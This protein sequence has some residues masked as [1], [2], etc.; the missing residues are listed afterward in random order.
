MEN[1]STV[2]EYYDGLSGDV[3]TLLRELR[4]LGRAAAPAAT[5]A[6]KWRHP[7]FV[8]PAGTILFMFSAHKSHVN[9]VF[10][11]STREAFAGVLTG[12]ETGKGSVQLPYGSTVPDDL[13]LR[14]MA[15]RIREFED[16]GVK[17]M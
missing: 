13:L 7:A 11:P 15:F 5:E 17:W 10:T 8:H 9:V 4:R 6:I 1:A 3:A 16:D 14:M 12:F 2:D